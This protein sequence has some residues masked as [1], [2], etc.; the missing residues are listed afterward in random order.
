MVRRILPALL[1]L[2]ACA[3]GTETTSPTPATAPDSTAG[4]PMVTMEAPTVENAPLRHREVHWFRTAAEY[5]AIALQTYRLAW[6]AVREHAAGREPDTWAVIMDADETVLDNSEFERRIAETG[7]EFEE[8]MW[9]DWVMEEA[10]ELVPGAGTFIDRVQGVGGRIA[11]V[12]NRHQGLCPATRRN[13]AELGVRPAVVLCETET[14][15]KEPRFRMV[16]EGTAH[17]TLPPLEVVAW[18]GDNIGDFPD[19]DQSIR[20]GPAEAYRLFGERYFVLPNPMYGSW[21][22]NDWR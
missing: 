5:R 16:R 15:E 1:V 9:D 13:L 20:T 14:G 3:P 11:I 8:S 10:A 2:A 4:A 18:V 19:L 17:D 22:G 12:T 21:M 7:E 6:D